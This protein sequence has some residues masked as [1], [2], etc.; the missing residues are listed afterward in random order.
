MVSQLENINR[1]KDIL[2]VLG[3][4]KIKLRKAIIKNADKDLIDAISQCVFN[5]LSGNIQMNE[6]EKKNL[7]KYKTTLRKI[8]TKSSLKS[9]KRILVQKGGFLQFLIPAAITGISSI[10][11]SLITSHSNTQPAQPESS[12]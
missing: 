9:K 8:A 11:S 10:I 6:L 1:Q 12:T 7:A 2:S 3:K 5:L 4:C